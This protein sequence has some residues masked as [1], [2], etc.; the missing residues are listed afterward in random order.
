[1]ILTAVFPGQESELEFRNFRSAEA[2]VYYMAKR[3]GANRSGK[4]TVDQMA[5][6]IR[7]AEEAKGRDKDSK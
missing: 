7:I 1:M 2:T 4:I 6:E 5:N 3:P